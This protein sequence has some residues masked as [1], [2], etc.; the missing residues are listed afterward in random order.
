MLPVEQIGMAAFEI[1]ATQHPVG[2]VLGVTSRGVFIAIDQHVVY[3]SSEPYRSPL[4]LNVPLF[5]SHLPSITPQ[6]QVAISPNQMIFK[7]ANLTLAIPPDAGWK[8]PIPAQAAPPATRLE[9]LRVLAKAAITG[10]IGGGFGKVIGPL[11]S[12]P[13][14]LPLSDQESAALR[15]CSE[16]LVRLCETDPD[17]VTEAAYP[18]LGLGPGLTPSGDD[19]NLGLLLALNRYPADCV[20]GLDRQRLNDRMLALARQRTTRISSELLWCAAQGEADE[21]LIAAV[22]A[23]WGSDDSPEEAADGLRSWGSSSGFDSLVGMALAVLS[24]Q[25]Q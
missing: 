4:T 9:N 22:D 13:L 12:L 1:L 3:V 25:S 8:S 15:R 11:L 19:I 14:D 17:G 23:I 10:G 7:A 6:S 21:R 5:H 16:L 20:S 18:L 2:T 24:T